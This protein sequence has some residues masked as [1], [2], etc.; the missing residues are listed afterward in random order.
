MA[1]AL[2]GRSA[3][4]TGASQGLGLA[5]AREFVAAGASVLVCARDAERLE[6]ARRELAA[7]ARPGQ[8]VRAEAADVGSRDDV[9]RL[10][11]AALAAFPDLHILVNNAGVYGP[12]GAIE[13]VDW[14][15]W[16]AAVTVNLFGSVLACRALLPHFKTRRYGKIIQLSGGGA[17]N[18]LPRISAYAASKAAVVRF[19]ETLAEEVR[20]Y[21]IDVNAVAPGALNTRLLDQVLESGPERVGGGFYARALKQKEGGGAP[22]ERGAA[23]AVFLASAASDGITGRL[24]SAV[25]D[26][27]ERLGDHR[28]DLERSDVYTLRR[29]VPADRGMKWG[30]R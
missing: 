15:D 26:P 4:I 22:L 30:D 1:R 28:A 6:E 5:I 21:G 20:E 17:T 18:P 3:L 27:W 25:W 12:M 16:L 7:L 29:I 11:A 14:D 8:Q 10:A 13:E 19:A 24:V 2:D 9:D 23:L